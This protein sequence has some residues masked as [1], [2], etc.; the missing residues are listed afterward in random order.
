[1][2]TC[3]TEKGVHAAM[4]P[5]D[6]FYSYAHEDEE[7]R[8]ELAGHLKI[9]ERRGVIRSWV[10]RDIVPGQEWDSEIKEALLGA[11]IVLLLVSA[12][13]IK[14][15]YIWGKELDTA[16][17][18]HQQGKATVIPVL[19]RATDIEGAPFAK[20][21]GLPKDFKA[22]TS[23]PNRDEAWTD[24]ARGIRRAAKLLLASTTRH[25]PP[26]G[27]SR[28]SRGWSVSGVTPDLGEGGNN[29]VDETLEHVLDACV[30]RLETAAQARGV[31][32]ERDMARHKALNLVDVTE[33]IRILWVDDHPENNE[34]EIAALTGLQIEVV[35][36]RDT[37]A[38]IQRIQEDEEP[39]DLLISDWTREAEDLQAAPSAAVALLRAMKSRK[40]ALPLLIYHGS[41]KKAER[42]ARGRMA[43]AEGAVAE[44]NHPDELFALIAGQFS[45]SGA[46]G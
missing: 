33:Q 20:L 12:D 41:F 42:D 26:P 8:D 34:S 4:N 27:P 9:L 23:W 40:I 10:D 14:S 45:G 35:T 38:A 37:D 3:K 39:F 44:T 16:M 24:V 6:L 28:G 21:Q 7:L 31:V 19:I 2:T 13:F 30:T 18:L 36:A 29:T 17:Q 5:L 32:L 1:M 11:D 22:V 43:L 15:D 46:A 25:P